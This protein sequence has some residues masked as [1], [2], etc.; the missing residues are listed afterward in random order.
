MFD[1]RPSK[2]IKII[3]PT[4]IAIPNNEKN[5]KKNGKSNE[6]ER[7]E[8]RIIS[9]LLRRPQQRQHSTSY[10]DRERAATELWNNS[11]PPQLNLQYYKLVKTTSYVH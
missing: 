1:K 2:S 3:V 9:F 7:D 10:I 11:N 4:T 6:K 8:R 5:S